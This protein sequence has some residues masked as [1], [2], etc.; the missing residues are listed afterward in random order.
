MFDV[1]VRSFVLI[2][3]SRWSLLIREY[4]AFSVFSIIVLVEQYHP[5]AYLCHVF[6][7]PDGLHANVKLHFLTT[8]VGSH[9]DYIHRYLL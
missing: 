2:I 4:F 5:F 6:K 7:S 3:K 8:I 1:L 9:L